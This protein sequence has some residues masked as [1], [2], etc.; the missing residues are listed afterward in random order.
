[1]INMQN[2]LI[3]KQ[4]SKKKR[5]NTNVVFKIPVSGGSTIKY[6]KQHNK[7]HILSHDLNLMQI[8]ISKMGDWKK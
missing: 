4:C 6:F 3:L 2:K 5:K 7:Q 8:D 1:M